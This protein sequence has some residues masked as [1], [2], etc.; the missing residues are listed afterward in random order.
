MRI[1]GMRHGAYDHTTDALSRPAAQVVADHH[2][3]TRSPAVGSSRFPRPHRRPD[4]R[5]L[6]LMTAKIQT[7]HPI[8]R[9][10]AVWSAS[11]FSSVS[12]SSSPP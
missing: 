11:C 7:A 8:G 1:A 4:S 6:R 2:D 9:G 10:L 12:P 5:T 3:G